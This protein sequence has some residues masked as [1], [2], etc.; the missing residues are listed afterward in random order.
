MIGKDLEYRIKNL[1]L[2]FKDTPQPNLLIALPNGNLGI[3][4]EVEVSTPEFTSLCPLNLSQPDYASI[5]ITY[6]PD[7]LLVELKSLKFYLA[8]FRMVPIFHEQIVPG[9]LVALTSL[10]DPKWIKIVG[11]FTV[12]GGLT[13]TIGAE[14]GKEILE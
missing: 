2:E 14:S 6:I 12:R 10:L 7:K 5:N 4:F 3:D 11:Y 13:T 1:K 8:S 9:I